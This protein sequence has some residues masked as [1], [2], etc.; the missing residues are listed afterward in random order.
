MARRLI[1]LATI[2][3]VLLSLGP[4][5]VIAQDSK[6]PSDP[7]AQAAGTTSQ[8]SVAKT[9]T[10]KTVG[11]VNSVAVCRCGRAFVPTA[12]TGTV[13]VEG[14]QYM[15]CSDACY[16]IALSDPSRAAQDSE[17]NKAKILAMHSPPTTA[18]P[19]DSKTY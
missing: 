1:T 4:L 2:A 18:A 14:K 19:S 17:A 16:K 3:A 5:V 13:T 15:T 12:M 11:P 6:K 10:P 8:L 9:A 7:A